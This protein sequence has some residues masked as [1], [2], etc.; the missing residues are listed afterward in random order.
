MLQIFRKAEALTHLK[1]LQIPSVAEANIFNHP[2]FL[3]PALKH[4]ASDNC[5]LLVRDNADNA[6]LMPVQVTRAGLGLRKSLCGW[7]NIYATQGTPLISS[8]DITSTL[9][10]V[11]NTLSKP[12]HGLPDTLILPDINLNAAFATALKD[13]A[14]RKN[15]P[16]HIMR[17]EE[18]PVL[19]NGSDAES[20][21]T[22]A[23]GKNHRREYRRQWRRLSET[24]NLQ[25]HI[26]ADKAAIPEAM[27]DFLTLEA[28]GW[29]GTRGTA[30][31]SKNAD[32]DFAREAVSALTELDLVR[33]HTLTL[34]DRLIASLVVFVQDDQAWTWK[35][36]YDE[37]LRAF[38]PG[39]LLMIEVLKNHLENPALRITDS[40]AIPDHPV[41]SRLFHERETFGTIILGLTDQS[42]RATDKIARQLRR[43]DRLRSL[44]RDIKSRLKR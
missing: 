25:Y 4:F 7:S 1:N 5:A 15:L 42:Q 21:L 35:T 39:V 19:C 33:I 29:K 41:M 26:I 30:F 17:Q 6:F 24:G 27:N 43:Y 14:Q 23:I 37:A 13:L 40:C 34:D 16:L 3:R 38:S 18:R 10:T 8:A 9:E 12:E 44:V 20:Y 22:N 2:D 36:A 32:A 28:A 31:L 11:L